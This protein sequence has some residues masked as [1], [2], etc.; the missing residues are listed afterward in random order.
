MASESITVTC[1]N[2][3]QAHNAMIA[4]VWPLLK[5]I[6]TA[7]KRAVVSL[8]PETRSAAQNRLMW[9]LLTAF[10]CQLDWPVNGQMVKMTPEEWKDVLTAAHQGETVRL[11]MGLSGGVVMLGQ[12]TST[13]SKAKFADFIE[14]LYATAALRGVNL[15]GWVDE[16]VVIYAQS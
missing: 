16:D 2:A 9:P 6:T 15:P 10:S 1:Y 7:G 14:F 11:A 4:Q 8:K 12:R 5:A 3:Q 13:F